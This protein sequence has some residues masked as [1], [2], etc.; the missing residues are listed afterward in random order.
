MSESIICFV[1][2]KTGN[3]SSSLVLSKLLFCSVKFQR[4]SL[5]RRTT[6]KNITSSLQ[7]K[8]K[9][10]KKFLL[11]PFGAFLKYR[12][13]NIHLSLGSFIF[14][15]RFLLMLVAF[16]LPIFCQKLQ[17]EK[18]VCLSVCQDLL[19]ALYSII[20]CS[21]IFNVSVYAIKVSFVTEELFQ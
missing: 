8:E 13:A 4:Q 21:I 5:V 3:D 15:P 16:S 11:F 10:A 6:Q 20:F 18:Y 12:A 1:R 17:K 9:C 7:V 2:E 14:S 19:I